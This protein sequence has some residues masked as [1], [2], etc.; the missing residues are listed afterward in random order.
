MLLFNFQHK[1]R[2]NSLFLRT[3]KIEYLFKTSYF[4]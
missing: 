1:K 3:A 2:N 4:I